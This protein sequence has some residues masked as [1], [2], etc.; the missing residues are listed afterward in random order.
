MLQS[1]GNVQILASAW[2]N[3]ASQAFVPTL[4]KSSNLLWTPKNSARNRPELSSSSLRSSSRP[5]V[6]LLDPESKQPI[7]RLELAA[8]VHVS[9]RSIYSLESGESKNRSGF[10]LGTLYTRLSGKRR[11]SFRLHGISGVLT[12]HKLVDGWSRACKVCFWSVLRTFDFLVTPNQ[13]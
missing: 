5:W 3:D 2:S 8:F 10:I 9:A 13:T 7:Q 4:P 12:L 11:E 6:A 1:L